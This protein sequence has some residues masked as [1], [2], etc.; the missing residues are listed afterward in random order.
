MSSVNWSCGRAV[1]FGAKSKYRLTAE[2][3]PQELAEALVSELSVEDGLAE[4]VFEDI[5]AVIPEIDG[6]DPYID[7]IVNSRDEMVKVE[8]LN[9]K[10]VAIKLAIESL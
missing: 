1:T 3:L 2:E 5:I 6:I 4:V 8:R 7:Q 10:R 9:N